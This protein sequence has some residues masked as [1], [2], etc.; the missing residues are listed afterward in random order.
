VRGESKKYLAGKVRVSA[1]RDLAWNWTREKITG[2]E[3]EVESR[4]SK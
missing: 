2:V 4:Q 3:E 1:V